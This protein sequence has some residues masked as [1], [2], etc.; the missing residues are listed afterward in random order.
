MDLSDTPE[1][2]ILTSLQDEKEPL[3][4]DSAIGS[5]AYKDVTKDKTFDLQSVSSY[6]SGE[7]LPYAPDGW[8]NAGDVWGW[9]VAGRRSKGGYFTDRSLIPPASLQKG[10]R[11]LEFRSKA[12]IKRYLHSNFPNMTLE[13]FFALFSWMIPSAEETPT[14]VE[15]DDTGSQRKSRRKSVGRPRKSSALVPVRPC[16]TPDQVAKFD[17]Y[18][19]NLD[20]MLDMPHTETTASDHATCASALDAESI[21]CC[22]K[23]LSSLLAL[24]FP[25]L[26]SSNDVA[27]VAILASQ[28]RE[29]PNLT[30]DQLFKLK[31]VEQVPLA[32][33]AF[34]EA[35]ESIE[36]ADKRMADL[37]AKKLEIPTLKKEYNEL[38]EK[39]SEREAEM[40]ISTLSIKEIDD[41]IRQLQLKRNR[42]SSALETMQKD[43]D[44]L[45]SELSNVANSIST[46]V[47]EI[48]SGLSQKSKW[49]LKKANNVRR[50]AEIQEKFVTL[51]GLTF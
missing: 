40:D 17:A 25:S 47:N 46:I 1:A 29:D 37:Q 44:K 8:P 14:K 11:K 27:E 42:I 23:K 39:L 34:L 30:V 51:R 20:D 38:K 5:N 21:E 26:V 4:D 18:L 19:D 24:D 49:D 12:D 7:G 3:K 6:S 2:L 22:K 9:K 41:Q 28:I 45:T 13:A 10:T 48:Q 15:D 43:K 16:V 35:K 33:E 36:E 32:G 31:L 50:V